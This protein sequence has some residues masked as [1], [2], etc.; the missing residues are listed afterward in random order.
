VT[1]PLPSA[2]DELRALD[3]RRGMV[4]LVGAA[5]WF[6]VMSALAKLA[7][8]DLPIA[9]AV[10]VRCATTLALTVGLVRHQGLSMR[11]KNVKLLVLRGLFGV[12]AVLCFF[13]A[14]VW[15]PIAE[16]TVIQFMN[17]LLA[18]LLA[19]AVLGER[20]GGSVAVGLAL[21]FGGMLLVARP[22][23][24]FGT[25]AALSQEGVLVGLAG[26]ALSACAYVTIRKV[27][28]TDHPDIVALYF[29]MIATPLTLVF[30]L[31]RWTWPTPRG[32]LLLFAVGVATH[33]GQ[34]M[35]T[36]GLA[37]VPASRGTAVGYL[38]IVFASLWGALLFDERPS[39]L[40]VVGA[41]LVLASALLLVRAP[42]HGPQR[43]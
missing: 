25:Q 35:M 21:G 39:G 2:D 14:I 6:S 11:G 37:R 24:L 13:H 3:E 4:T 10:F 12:A 20:P 8:R 40:T 9:M 33:L 28:R 26:A 32:W 41:A 42:S 15:L 18:T 29:P 36:R 22:A 1:P 23:V 38:Q 31:P 17:P 16:A 19:M 43:S 30:A 5:F 27:T 34:L 7:G